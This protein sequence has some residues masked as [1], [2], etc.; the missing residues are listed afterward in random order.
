MEPIDRSPRVR[1][2]LLGASNLTRGISTVVESAQ[3]IWGSPLD[4]CCALG[5][6][7]SYGWTSNFLGRSLPGIVDCGLWKSLDERPKLPTA[8]LITDIGNDLMYGAAVP[9]IAGWIETAIDRLQSVDAQVAMTLLP[10]SSAVRLSPARFR[11]FAKLFFPL[12]HLELSDLLSRGRE[13]NGRLETLGRSRGVT[14]IEQQSQWYGIDPIHIRLRYWRTVWPSI[15]A[16]TH[17][18]SKSIR[19]TRGSF[20]RWIYLRTRTAESWRL[21][22]VPQRRH[23]PSGHLKDG[24]SVSLF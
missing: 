20:R 4:I 15:L 10:M 16:A 2:V 1:V 7:R 19:P 23:Q 6:G 21:L 14:L 5:H 18:E 24:S 8:A 17:G 22:G 11:F 13:L 9:Q 12:K 3:D